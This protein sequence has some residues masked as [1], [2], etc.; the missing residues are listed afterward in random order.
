LLTLLFVALES[1]CMHLLVSIEQ[2]VLLKFHWF[3]VFVLPN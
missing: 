1:V 2:P 3:L